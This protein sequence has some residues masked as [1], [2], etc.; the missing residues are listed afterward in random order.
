MKDFKS[1]YGP[2]ALITGASAGIGAEFARQLAARGLDLV[3]VARRKQALDT[4]AGT[5]TRDHGIH[6]TTM[7]I[8]LSEPDFL[9]KIIPLTA[10]MEI[11][12]LVNNAGFAITGPFLKTPLDD[13]LQLLHLNTRAPL[14]LTHHFGNRMLPRHRGGII[15]LSSIA[16]FCAIP[17]WSN[18][19]ATKSWNL[20]MGEALYSEL[21][22]EGIDVLSVCPGSTV[23]EF[24]DVAGISQ[25]GAMSA[26]RVVSIALGSL[27]KGPKVV[28]GFHNRALVSL[29]KYLPRQLNSFLAGKVIGSLKSGHS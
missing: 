10:A 11:G 1:R 13:E 17:T 15:F 7:A 21:A 22:P 24:G 14:I 23:S 3:L 28:T 2:T 25:A 18:Y 26:T 19:S 29:E 9:S 27:G 20:I 6:C 12:L 16:A 5:L 8:D 4:L